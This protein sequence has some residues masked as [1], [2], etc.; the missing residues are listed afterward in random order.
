MRASRNHR[1]S[2]RTR[3]GWLSRDGWRALGACFCLAMMFALGAQI[4][5]WSPLTGPS[6][7][8]QPVQDGN[9]FAIG[10]IL[11]V[12]IYGNECGQR[13]IDNATWR[14]W[15]NGVVQCDVA[16]TQEADTRAR[17]LS[18]LRVDVIRSGFT[19]R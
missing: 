11:I 19:K 10:T 4:A 3:T 7:V 8:G 14:I 12:P 13:L 6:T 5:D 15:D 18:A 2:E 17:Q 1:P 9:A 16:L